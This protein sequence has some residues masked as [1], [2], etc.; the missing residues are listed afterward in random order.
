MICYFWESLKPSIK[1]E[2]EQQDRESM[3][4]EEMVQKAVNTEAKAGLRS[5]IMVQDLDIRCPRDHCP[6]NSTASKVQ[7][8][9]ITVKESKSEEFRPKELKSTKNKKSAPPHFKFT[10][11]GKTSRIDK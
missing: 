1:A 10:K 7:I 3:N 6:S 9:G 5:S 4:F 8:Q 11:P 2:I